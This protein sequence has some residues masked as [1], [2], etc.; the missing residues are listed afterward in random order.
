MTEKKNRNVEELKTEDLAA[1]SGGDH[2]EEWAELKVWAMRHNPEWAKE[3]PAEFPDGPVVRWLYMNIPEYDGSAHR[4]DGPTTYF[5]KGQDT[6]TMNH[7]EM[8]A[9]LISKYGE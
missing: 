3:D 2:T 9:L 1:V 7:E 8:M 6:Q 4:D 5:V